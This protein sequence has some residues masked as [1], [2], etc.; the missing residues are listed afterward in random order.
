MRLDRVASSHAGKTTVPK[1]Y[2]VECA[3]CPMCTV[4]NVHGVQCAPCQGVVAYGAMLP[5]CAVP[6]MYGSKVSC[7]GKTKITQRMN[8]RPQSLLL[9]AFFVRAEKLDKRPSFLGAKKKGE[10][11]LK[12]YKKISHNVVPHLE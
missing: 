2:V 4:P 9:H 1:V 11:T 6:N 7:C 10:I 12:I 5:C 3:L 8:E